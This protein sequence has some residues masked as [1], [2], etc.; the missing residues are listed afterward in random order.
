MRKFL[1]FSFLIIT[2]ILAGCTTTVNKTTPTSASTAGMI[3]PQ[4]ISKFGDIPVPSGFKLVPADSYSFEN[5]GVRVGL[6]KYQGRGDSD[7]L[8]NFYKEQMSMY[9]WRLLNVVE[10]GERMLNFDREQETCIITLQSKG[11]KNVQIV[12]ALGPKAQ[13][14]KKAIK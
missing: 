13:A 11:G 10:F 6:L 12:I 4:T 8:I 3:E 7:Q 9:N 14:T 2:F 5:S 1:V